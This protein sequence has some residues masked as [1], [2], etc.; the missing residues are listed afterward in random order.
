MVDS[1]SMRFRT[2]SGALVGIFAGSLSLVPGCFNDPGNTGQDESGDSGTTATTSSDTSATTTDTGGPNCGNGMVEGDEECDLGADNDD[3]GECT[4]Q[5]LD[6]VCGDGLVFMG[7]EA[8]DE[9][10]ASA[11]CDADC[12]VPE[13]GDGVL[14]TAAGEICEDDVGNGTCNANCAVDCN[15][16][17]ANCD[18]TPDCETDVFTDEANCGTCGE[19]CDMDVECN[20]GTCGAHLTFVTDS[21][22]L[23][24]TLVGGVTGMNMACQLEATTAGLTG[25]YLAWADGNLGNFTQST[26]PYV[27][28]D[29]ALVA[30]NWDDLIDGDIDAPINLNAVG[31]VPAVDGGLCHG[32]SATCPFVFSGLTPEGMSTGVNCGNW[33]DAGAN[34]TPGDM[35]ETETAWTQVSLSSACSIP[36]RLYCFQ[37]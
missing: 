28:S 15:V 30:D 11:N 4:T 19:T 14:N 31:G 18:T 27:R 21:T 34:F 36:A 22:Y 12:T 1:N 33:L 5:C 37:Q 16:G 13:C 25:N 6:A 29:G 24:S 35:T 32:G 9:G 23:L 20:K 17:F 8:C 10:G 2:H 3:E 7:V 26:T